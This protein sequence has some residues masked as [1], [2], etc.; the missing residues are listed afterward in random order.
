MSLKEW[1]DSPEGDLAI[2]LWLK[3]LWWVLIP[4]SYLLRNNIAWVVLMS[5]Y[6]IIVS[7]WAGEEGAKAT[8]A[9]KE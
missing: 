5:H 1:W 6:A 3:R 7:H 9:A 8:L 4:F 2:H